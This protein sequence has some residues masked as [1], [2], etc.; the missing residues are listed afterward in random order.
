MAS[1]RIAAV[2][3]A[4]AFGAAAPAPAQTALDMRT[5]LWEVKS[6]RSSTGMPPMPTM[7]S[8]PPEALAKLPPAQRAQIEN[9]MK[10][11][12]SM[13]TGTRVSK[14]CVTE[15]GLRKSPDFSMADGKM[16]CTRT[17]ESRTARGWQVEEACRSDGGT[18]T[19]SVRYEVVNRE[20]IEGTVDIAMRD[21]GHDITMKQ[22][23]HGRWLGPDC[24]DVKPM[25]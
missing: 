20:T 18:Q 2:T 25:E 21:R 8:I 12:G 11:R 17:Q 13:A 3:A 1:F 4:V 19:V 15:E 7:P 10:A 6:E 16:R 14:F 24:G 5:G 23:M 22:T 9:A